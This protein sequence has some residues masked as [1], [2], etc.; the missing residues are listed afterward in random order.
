[1]VTILF[2]AANPIDTAR[3]KLDEEVRTIDLALRQSKFRDDFKLEIHNALHF[4]DL[5][6]LLLRYEPQIVHF[7]GHGSSTNE[8][9]L[10]D[11]NGMSHPV[12][13][14]ALSEL[15]EILADN[16][17][18]VVLNACYSVVQA[19]AIAEHI[20]CVIGMSEIAGDTTAINFATSF[21]QALAFGRDIKTAFQLGC[22]QINLANLEEQNM[23]QLLLKDSNSSS[24]VLVHDHGRVDSRKVSQQINIS[25]HART[26]NIT[27]IG[28][29]ENYDR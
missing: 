15:F 5:Q 22:S 20:D 8:L 3:L 4:T 21:Y 13:S 7:A 28:N 17:R 1:M 14:R 9:I 6:S 24:I 18:C 2:L 10:M 27:Q 25:G 23:P 29:L 26:G 12:S 19:R 11:Q 16:I